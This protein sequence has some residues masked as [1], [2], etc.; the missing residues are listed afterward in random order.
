[1]KKKQ[2]G[3]QQVSEVPINN[4]IEARIV[5]KQDLT[6]GILDA[7]IDGDAENFKIISAKKWPIRLWYL[8]SNPF[9]YLFNG[10]YRY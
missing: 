2:Q 10:Y 5:S 6:F 9:C 4:P 1:M 7:H 3:V 8:I